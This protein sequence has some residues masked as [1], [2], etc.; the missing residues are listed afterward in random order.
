MSVAKHY[1]VDD[2][3]QELADLPA[4]S[5]PVA[6]HTTHIVTTTT[7]HATKPFPQA[8][9]FMP[10]AVRQQHQNQQQQWHPQQQRQPDDLDSLLNELREDSMLLQQML[11][12][13]VASEGPSCA[14][15]LKCSS[16]YLGGSKDIRG[17]SQPMQP[18]PCC[19]D[20]L[21]C[22][23]C[24]FRVLWH[25]DSRWAAEVDYMFFRNSYGVEAQL[26]TQ[27]QSSRGSAAMCCQCSWVTCSK[28][29][30]LADVAQEAGHS[31]RWIC[32]GHE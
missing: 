29:T 14:G 18:T 19:C 8:A 27:L 28:A 31:L 16:I 5:K 6:C 12:L 2:L 22:L 25:A 32:R 20:R 11:S 26:A 10:S 17:C 15:R 7:S 30:K 24:D 23:S 13:K 3:L 21:K 9:A 4:T 1:T